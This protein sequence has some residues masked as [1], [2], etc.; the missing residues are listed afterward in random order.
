MATKDQI[1]LFEAIK[2]HRSAL[3]IERDAAL[4]LACWLWCELLGHGI[5]VGKTV[6]R[7]S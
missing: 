5:V 2:T 3:E 4:G 1:D 6:E 7:Q